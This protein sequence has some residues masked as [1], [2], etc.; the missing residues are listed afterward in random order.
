MTHARQDQDP[1]YKNAW[2][3][4]FWKEVKSGFPSMMIMQRYM[5]DATTLQ[6]WTCIP[7]QTLGWF[8]MGVPVTEYGALK[9]GSGGKDNYGADWS[10]ED[11]AE[12]TALTFASFKAM[13]KFPERRDMV[14]SQIPIEM[15]TKAHIAEIDADPAAFGYGEYGSPERFPYTLMLFGD[16][17]TIW[18]DLTKGAGTTEGHLRYMSSAL[19]L[20]EFD[21]IDNKKIEKEEKDDDEQ[22]P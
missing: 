12:A 22:T 2:R 20:G 14:K 7:W 9:P 16:E 6:G 13:D 18:G 3:A 4:K 17:G 1:A 10:H 8:P 19:G 21:E 5:G 15:Y 11:Q